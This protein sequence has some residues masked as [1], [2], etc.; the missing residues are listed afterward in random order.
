MNTLATRTEIAAD[1]RRTFGANALTK[2]QVGEYMGYK[3]RATY[4][5]LRDVDASPSPGGKQ[6]RYLVI[7]LARKI[8][9]VMVPGG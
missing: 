6:K 9:R 4:D 8:E 2:K 1:L 7:D 3:P 5:F